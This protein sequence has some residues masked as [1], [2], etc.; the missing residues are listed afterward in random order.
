MSDKSEIVEMKIYAIRPHL[1]GLSPPLQGVIL[2]ELLTIWLA[3]HHSADRAATREL[4]HS[5]LRMHVEFVRT[6]LDKTEQKK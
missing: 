5:L 1:A 4:R 2:A 3:G 6:Q